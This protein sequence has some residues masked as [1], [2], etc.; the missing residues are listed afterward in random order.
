MGPGIHGAQG[1]GKPAA[2]GLQAWHCKILGHLKAYISGVGIRFSGFSQH[3]RVT[4]C[5]TMV[6]TVWGSGFLE[7]K[8]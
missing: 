4:R 8:I 6:F 5:Y 7:S 2:K 1:F 3:E